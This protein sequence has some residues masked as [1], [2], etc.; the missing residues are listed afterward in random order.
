MNDCVKKK[1]LIQKFGG[2]PWSIC[3]TRGGRG[4]GGGRGRR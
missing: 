2:L 4:E 1:P 3:A